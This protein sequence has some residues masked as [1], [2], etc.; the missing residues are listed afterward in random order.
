MSNEAK[1]EEPTTIIR[2]DADVL[3]RARTLAEEASQKIGVRIKP[4]QIIESALREKW[5]IKSP[6]SL[7]E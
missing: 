3:E 7:G 1:A 5:G 2:L 4:R 6:Q